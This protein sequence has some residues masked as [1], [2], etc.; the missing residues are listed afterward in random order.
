VVSALGPLGG[1]ASSPQAAST[2]GK[3]TAATSRDVERV[4]RLSNARLKGF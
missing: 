4:M 2:R 3:P 1:T